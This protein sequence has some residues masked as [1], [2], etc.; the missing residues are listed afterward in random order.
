M[1]YLKVFENFNQDIDSICSS[2]GIEDYEV[3]NGLV[4]VNGDVN[5][6]NNRLT[7]LPLKFGEVTGDFRCNG[8]ELTSL[9][10]CP[11]SVGGN[12]Y[13]GYN[14][15]TSLEGCPSSVGGYFY[16]GYNKLTS[17]EGCPSSVGGYFNC[18][19]NKLTSLEGCPSSVGGNFYCSNNKLIDLLGIDYIGRNFYC[20]YNPVSKLWNL[21]KDNSKIELFNYIDTVRPAENEGEQP[22]LYLMAINDFLKQIGKDPVTE[23]EGYNCE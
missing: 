17:L 9:E 19:Y 13:C 4:N 11:S 5:L 21:F 8:N 2:Y 10:G 1:R 12:F 16:C 3:V 14:K 7:K 22:T 18:S 20:D 23:V 15:L 6:Y